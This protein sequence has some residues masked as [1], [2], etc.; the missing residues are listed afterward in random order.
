MKAAAKERGKGSGQQC[1]CRELTGAH[2]RD[3][4]YDLEPSE[5]MAKVMIEISQASLITEIL[6]K[7]IQ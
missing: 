1:P 6:R 7:P 2:T 3:K 4:Q 5:A